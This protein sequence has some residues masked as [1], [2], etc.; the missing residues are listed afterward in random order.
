MI[1]TQCPTCGH[2]LEATSIGG[3]CFECDEIILDGQFYGCSGCILAARRSS[4]EPAKDTREFAEEVASECD[5]SPDEGTWKESFL[6]ALAQKIERFAQARADE[7]LKIAYDEISRMDDAWNKLWA[8]YEAVETELA[9]LKTSGELKYSEGFDKGREYGQLEES[10]KALKAMQEAAK[11]D[12]SASELDERF[13]PS[14]R[15]AKPAPSAKGGE[16]D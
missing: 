15:F 14:S 1:I 9:A 11:Q 6:I 13:P 12:F 3:V 8:K 2:Q 5:T 16:Y 7:K 10:S 4:A